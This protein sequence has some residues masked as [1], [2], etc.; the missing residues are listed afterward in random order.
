MVLAN[1]FAANRS[2][3]HLFQQLFS[4]LIFDSLIFSV[5]WTKERTRYGIENA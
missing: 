4:N 1:R 3:T 5:D 2:G